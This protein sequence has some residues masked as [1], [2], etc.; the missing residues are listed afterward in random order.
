MSLIPKIELPINL[1]L[2]NL[3]DQQAFLDKQRPFLWEKFLQSWEEF[4]ILT[5]PT[6]IQLLE[7]REDIQ[8]PEEETVKKWQEIDISS[9]Q[10]LIIGS[11]PG[12]ALY[13]DNGLFAVAHIDQDGT[14]LT[15]VDSSD[16]DTLG[17][18]IFEGRKRFDQKS[19]LEKVKTASFPVL[20]TMVKNL[21]LLVAKARRAL[22][23]TEK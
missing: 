17:D 20:L 23:G 18:G 14:Y 13:K 12:F 19:N 4:K 5:A 10:F 3:E 22:E 6:N 8:S 2:D 11:E 7:Q 1:Y 9:K 16:P 15:M 21:V